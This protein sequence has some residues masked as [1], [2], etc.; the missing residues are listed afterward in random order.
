MKKKKL[1]TF[2]SMFVVGITIPL[3]SQEN[4]VVVEKVD[5]YQAGELAGI[6]TGDILISWERPAN[7]P[8]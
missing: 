3:F 1:M 6:K 8:G 2:F 5:K 7:P 4:G